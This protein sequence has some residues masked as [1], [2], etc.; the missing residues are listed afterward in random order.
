[1]KRLLDN[2]S[3]STYTLCINLIQCLSHIFSLFACGLPRVGDACGHGHGL[4]AHARG[5]RG[6]KAPKDFTKP[7]QAIVIH[8]PDTTDYTK[9]QQTI[10][11]PKKTIQSPPKSIQSLKLLDKDLYLLDKTKYGADWYSNV[12]EA[13]DAATHTV[14]NS[15]D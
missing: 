14:N 6:G 5:G 9:P 13:K 1:M 10:Q 7:R 3:Q 12:V 8:S 4:L 11:S 15:A 2:N